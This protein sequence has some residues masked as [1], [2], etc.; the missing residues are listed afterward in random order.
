MLVLVWMF[1]KMLVWLFEVVVVVVVVAPAAFLELF[2]SYIHVLC[3]FCIIIIIS[4][5]VVYQ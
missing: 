3:F 4:L 2:L 1:R 5:D